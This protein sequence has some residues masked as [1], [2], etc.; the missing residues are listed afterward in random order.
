MTIDDRT[1]VLVGVGTAAQRLDD[2]TEAKEAVGLMADALAAAAD[3]AGS[4]S[5]IDRLDQVRVTQGT[6]GYADPARW[7]A[8]E[9]GATQA[10]SYLGDVGILQTAVMGDA[11]AAIAS[12][13]ADVIAVVGGEAKYRGLRA[14]ITGIEAPD[15]DQGGA[16]PDDFVTPHGMIISRA[17]IDTGLV[18]ATHHY[19]M[20]ENARR[21]A[22]G[23][24]IEE[25][26]DEVAG[27]WAR[28][29]RVAAAN[30]DAWFRDGLDAA[31]IATPENGNRMLAWPYTKWHNS[32]WNVDQAAALIFCSAGTARAL[33]I[34]SDRWVFPCAAAESNHMV[35]VTE[36]PELH[37]S[38]GF[39]YVGR[40]VADHVGMAPSE[41]GHVDLYS[42]FPIA[43][44]TQALEL[45]IDLDRDLT[46]TG[47]MTWAGG[48]LNNYVIQAAVRMVQVLRADPV[49]TGLLTSISGMI[50]KQGASV[51][52]AEP[53]TQPFANLDVTDAVAAELQPKPYR[54]G[55]NETAEVVSYTVIWGRDGPERAVVI[56]EFADGARTL[57]VSA[58]PAVMASAV[59]G[60]FCGRHVIAGADGSFTPVD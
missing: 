17:E 45:D 30:P 37:R 58:V 47:G 29:A 24:S 4:S 36:R 48:P 8:D 6:W 59:A 44:R 53:P 26:R 21:F 51:W 35:P 14:S 54:T 32:Q 43:V 12:G 27:L 42:C 40:A 19:A 55:D 28:F 31:A 16:E 33:G 50:T 13:S 7:V 34:S 5:L 25:H 41:A 20:I 10:R 18:M 22:D 60:E 11:A 49:S 1:P 38:P 3:D 9:V 57:L 39:A 56:G 2:P 52:S 15:T 23:Q 46:V